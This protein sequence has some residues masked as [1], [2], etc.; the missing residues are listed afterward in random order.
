MNTIVITSEMGIRI[1]HNRESRENLTVLSPHILR[2]RWRED[3]PSRICSCAGAAGNRFRTLRWRAVADH[4]GELQR[5]AIDRK[6]TRL[7]SS[8]LGISYAVFCLKKK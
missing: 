6:S 1:F 2:N 7:N 8:H 3:S 4:P 5:S